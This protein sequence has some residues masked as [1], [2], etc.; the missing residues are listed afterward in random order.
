MTPQELTLSQGMVE[1]WSSFGK[2]GKPECEWL[3][4]GTRQCHVWM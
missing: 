3:S 4:D 1:Y 2:T